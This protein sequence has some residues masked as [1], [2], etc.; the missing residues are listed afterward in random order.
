MPRTNDEHEVTRPDDDD[1]IDETQSE[2]LPSLAETTLH[3][4]FQVG[5]S[6]SLP[7]ADMS[8]PGTDRDDRDATVDE[9]HPAVAVDAELSDSAPALDPTWIEACAEDTPLDATIDTQTQSEGAS[10]EMSVHVTERTV[11]DV[12]PSE[13]NETIAGDPADYKLLNVLGKGGMGIVWQAQQSSID[14]SVAVKMT[15]NASDSP[16]RNSE[17]FLAEAMITGALEHPNIVPI[18]DLGRASDGRL[19]YVMKQVQGTPWKDVLGEYTLQENLRTLQRACDAVAFANSRGVVHRDLKPENIML[20]EF[21]E[22]LVMDWGLALVMGRHDERNASLGGTPGYMAPEMATGPISSIGPHSDIYLLGAIL[23]ELVTGRKPHTGAD[24]MKC[25][26]AAAHNLIVPVKAK[27]ELIDIARKAMATDPAD[28]HRSVQEFQQEIRDYSSHQES[29]ALVEKATEC[30]AQAKSSSNYQAYSQ[31]RYG[32]Q[33]A[34]DL[35]DGNSDARAGLMQTLTECARTALEKGDYELGLS[36]LQPNVPEHETLRVELA[37]AQS[38]REARQ[39]RL[40]T[41]RRTAV[42]LGVGIVVVMLVAVVWISK[43]EQV[44]RNERDIAQT[45]RELAEAN[46]ER[47]EANFERAEKNFGLARSAVDEML[48]DVGEKKLE[49]VP[50]MEPV[51]RSLLKKALGFYSGFLKDQPDDPSLRSDTAKAQDRVGDILRMLGQYQE[52]TTA[53]RPAIS[54]FEQLESDYPDNTEY[55]RLRAEAHNW[56][57]E[58]LRK[59]G[60]TEDAEEQFLLARER[61]LALVQSLPDEPA[62]RRELA[63][64]S[65]NQ[66]LLYYEMNQPDKSRAAYDSAVTELTALVNAGADTPELMV[67]TASD[68]QELARAYLNRGI[69]NRAT[70]MSEAARSD[71]DQAIE[72]LRELSEASPQ[73]AEYRRELATVLNNLGNLLLSDPNQR[74]EADAVYREGRSIL[75]KLAADFPSTPIYR[76][77]LA[78]AINSLAAVYFFNKENDDAEELWDRSSAIAQTLVDEQPDIPEYRSLLART[79]GNLGSLKFRKEELENA[80]GL[81]QKAIENQRVVV[82]MNPKNPGFRAELRNYVWSVTE[83]HLALKDHASAATTAVTLPDALD[84]SGENY[85]AA[86]MLARCVKLVQDDA[87]LTDDER[88]G[89]ATDYQTK[90]LAA[91]NVAIDRGWDDAAKLDSDKAF[92]AFRDSEPFQ[93]ARARL[94]QKTPEES[95]A[96]DR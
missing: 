44:A 79:L 29:I 77:E 5:G 95:D 52:S 31:A 60:E 43:A 38:E 85:R 61:Q 92:S 58:S 81:L 12:T 89:L 2:I 14:R 30:L 19:F 37:A 35:W 21:G 54:L 39:H 75:E 33:S 3:E 59:L 87:A 64:T 76:M 74:E 63:R 48:T 13:S 53:Y 22:V 83:A 10:F 66:G 55:Q 84:E 34:I 62:I 9:V 40:K 11:A 68:R 4:P 70:Q 8:Q 26:L 93:A 24:V 32:F 86:T 71:Y 6:P 57:G 7:G 15:L 69:L 17:K 65:N 42:G 1:P 18:Y 51:Q 28:R 27:G 91:L 72:A 80:R 36:V 50:Q 82:R 45:Q 96:S 20:G 73:N 23:F 49:Y 47:A 78:N 56:F 46:F 88:S 16:D 25:L 41:V 67:D 94:T 90:S